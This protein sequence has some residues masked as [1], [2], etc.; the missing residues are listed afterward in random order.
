MDLVTSLSG[1]QEEKTYERFQALPW[2]FSLPVVPLMPR[3]AHAFHPVPSCSTSLSIEKA[4][5][6][7]GNSLSTHVETNVPREYLYSSILHSS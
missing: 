2:A 7:E 1:V 6:V 3:T 4:D 5:S